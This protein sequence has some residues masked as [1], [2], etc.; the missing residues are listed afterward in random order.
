MC[1]S[2]HT[3]P[4]KQL[5]YVTSEAERGRTKDRSFGKKRR[6]RAENSSLWIL[7]W[8]DMQVQNKTMYLMVG[9]KVC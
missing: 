5:W 1:S 9:C 4:G 6:R 7:A 3:T 8:G 2:L